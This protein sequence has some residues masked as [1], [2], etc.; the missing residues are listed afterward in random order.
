MRMLLIAYDQ[1]NF[2]NY[3]P[4]GLAYVAAEWQKEGHDIIVYQQDVY[5]YPPEH[6]AGYLK[7]NEFDL[8]GVGMCAGYYQYQ[9][10]LEIAQAVGKN[11][12]LIVGGH[13]VS[14]APEYFRQKLSQWCDVD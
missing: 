2:I 9:R 4:L 10:L 5:H 7:E 3:F 6:L 8:V 14:A 13:I 11:A 12:R 1:G